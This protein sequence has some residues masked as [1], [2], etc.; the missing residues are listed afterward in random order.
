MSEE[1]GGEKVPLWIISFA[2]MITLLLAFFVMLQTMAHSRDNTLMRGTQRGFTMA[3]R[4]MGLPDF[5]FADNDRTGNVDYRR[6]KYPDEFEAKTPEAPPL[7]SADPKDVRLEEVY[8]NIVRTMETRSQEVQTKWMATFPLTAKFP[9]QSDNLDPAV[10]DILRQIATAL[11]AGAG[12]RTFEIM[13][14]ASA[15]EERDPVAQWQLSALRAAAIDSTLA[16]ALK[17]AGLTRPRVSTLPWGC[18]DG[19]MIQEIAGG[20]GQCQAVVIVRVRIPQ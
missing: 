20:H 18:G 2:D 11:A 17:A 10:K 15:P 4:H 5:L 7:R 19:G 6:L 8:R 13:I 16:Q 14:L 12:S 3:L 1:G 9:A